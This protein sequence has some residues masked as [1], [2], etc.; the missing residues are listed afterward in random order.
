MPLKVP[1]IDRFA[2]FLNSR[3]LRE[4]QMIII[5][6]LVFIFFLDILLVIQPFAKMFT[7]VAPKITPLKEELKSLRDDLKNK[8]QI[9][10]RWEDAKKEMEEKE[11]SFIAPDET[12]ALLENLSKEAQKSG[13]KITSLEPSD[14]KAS[15][16]KSLYAVLPIQVKAGAGTHELGSFLSRLQNSATFFRVA[17]LKINTNPINERKHLIEITMEALK[18][19][20]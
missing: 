6:G 10:Q 9:R 15:G 18:K 7:E 13:V 16:S 8:T 12:P 2:N 5:F 20:K 1:G 19:D 14:S 17:D 3:T 11:R 4:K